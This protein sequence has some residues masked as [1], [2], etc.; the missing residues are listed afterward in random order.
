MSAVLQRFG[1]DAHQLRVLLRLAWRNET[2]ASRMSFGM[3]QNGNRPLLALFGSLL[4][5]LFAGIFAAV[6][7]FKTGTLFSA[8]LLLNTLVLL[9]LGGLIL[10][11]YN[12]VILSPDDYHILGYMPVSS[13][14][15]L[16]ARIGNMLLY[17]LLF[18]VMIAGPSVLALA[19]MYNFSL[20]VFIASSLS[21]FLTAVLI[22][23]AVVYLYGLL[24]NLLPPHKLNTLLSFLQFGLSMAIYSSYLIL[25]RFLSNDMDMIIFDIRWYMLVLPPAWFAA[26]ADL[27]VSEATTLHLMAILPGVAL[28]GLLLRGLFSRVSIEY[29]RAMV[30][31]TENTATPEKA[32]A[33]EQSRSHTFSLFR[34]PSAR[35]VTRLTMA[36]FRYDN[37]FKLSVIGFLPLIL[38]YFYMG[39]QRGTFPDPF[40]SGSTGLENFSVLYFAILMLPLIMKQNMEMSDAS[41]AAWVF[42]AT[43]VRLSGLILATRNMLFLLFAGPALLFI[44]VIFGYF[45]QNWLHAFLHLL[46][47]TALNFIM[48][49]IIYI[50]KPRL[51]FAE[52]KVRSGQSGLFAFLFF[53]LPGIG[54]GLL[55]LIVRLAYDSAGTLLM[56]YTLL[57]LTIAVLEKFSH[58]RIASVAGKLHFDGKKQ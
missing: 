7:M 19:Y 45:F 2:R 13:R 50:V 48:L 56:L 37:R 54:L 12:S 11:E 16:F 52:P 22:C 9:M 49:Q 1:V 29:A 46:T 14:T 33:R 4:F 25:P 10:V 35:I 41:E 58:M 5:Y 8:L 31:L 47:I 39:L 57:A 24:L 40:A 6:L 20:P 36:Q 30:A 3:N 23:L 34:S 32:G 18:S 51:P 26:L 17:L 43:P 53:I 15:F 38:I 28:S 21:V 55:Y 44:F 27:A 42:Y